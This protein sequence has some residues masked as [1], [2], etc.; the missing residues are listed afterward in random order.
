MN[1]MIDT[2]LIMYWT[3]DLKSSEAM[4]LE[5]IKTILAI[6]YR[7]AWKIQDFNRDA[8]REHA[9]PVHNWFTTLCLQNSLIK[10]KE[11]GLDEYW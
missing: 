10:S 4:I 9:M 7:E 3:A 1:K 11:S 8:T 5:V 2:K 6:A